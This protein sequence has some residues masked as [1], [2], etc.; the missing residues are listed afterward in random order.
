MNS[1]SLAPP[2]RRM[3]GVKK[4]GNCI[5]SANFSA[6]Y[7]NNVDGL[8]IDASNNGGKHEPIIRTTEVSLG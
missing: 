1:V 6:Y 8:I 2:I 7:Q 4:S 5:V 3:F